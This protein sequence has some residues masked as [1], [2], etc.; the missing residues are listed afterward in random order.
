VVLEVG[1]CGGGGWIGIGDGGERKD[2]EREACGAQILTT[3]TKSAM[4]ES[5]QLNHS[6]MQMQK[7]QWMQRSDFSFL[8][9]S[10]A[11]AFR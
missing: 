3:L 2:V 9:S 11:V 10:E 4:G 5:K 6:S 7:M 1:G 8:R